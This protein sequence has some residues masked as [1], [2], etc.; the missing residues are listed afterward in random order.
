MFRH[1]LCWL[2]LATVPSLAA[3]DAALIGQPA[4]LTVV[5]TAVT[6]VGPLDRAQV[7][8]TGD[9]NRD[10]TPVADY[11]VEPAHVASVQAGYLRPLQAG[12]ATLVIR[13]GT[14]TLRVPVTVQANPTAPSFRQQVIAALNV[15]GCNAGACHGTPSGKNGFKLSLRG[16][17]PAADFLQLTR[18]LQGRRTDRL[19]PDH[20]LLVQKGLGQTAHEGSQRW[21]T[22]GLAVETVQAWIAAGVPDDAPQLP[23]LVGVTVTP[24]PRVLGQRWQQLAVVARWADGR[25]RDVTRLSNFSS[26]DAG[27]AD[28]TAEGVLEFR[29]P[30]EVSVLVRYLETLVAVRFLYLEPKPGLVWSAPPAVNFV[31]THVHNKLKLLSLPAAPVCDDSTFLRRS[32]LDILGRLPTALEARNF[33]NNPAADKRN[34][35]LDYLLQQ[36]EYADFWALKW[37]DVLRANRKTVQL[38]GVFKYQRWLRQQLLTDVPFDAV[39]RD[40]LT[41]TGDTFAQPAANF[42]RANRDPLTLAET[43]AQLFLGV[44]LQCAKCHNHPFEQWTQDDYYRFA[45][46]F[47]R[48][49]AR[50]NKAK[51]SA[52]TIVVTRAGEVIHPRTGAVALPHFPGAG[53]APGD[54]DRRQALV[55]WLTQRDN[56]FFAKAVVNRVWYHL[57]GR[58]IVEPVDDFRA[59]N[60]ACNDELLTALANDWVQ[61]GYNFRHLLRTIARSHTYQASATPV[62]EEDGRYFS[63]ATPRLLTAEQ[64]LDAVADVTGVAEKFGGLPMGTRAIQVA[65]AGEHAF[66][67]SF[68]QPARELACECERESASN[69]GQALQLLNGTTVHDKIRAANNRLRDYAKVPASE[70]LDELYLTALARWPKPTERAAALAHLAGRAHSRAAWEDVLWALLNTKEFVFRP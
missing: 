51:E 24:G 34:H 20:S 5:P 63:H 46:F 19:R 45:A 65:D 57:H 1:S 7:V 26:S 32:S 35:W 33:A 38:A 13:A 2:F 53:P 6:L 43:T 41:A 39:V 3:P 47:A 52:E 70:L 42:Y 14:H 56:P 48:V 15:G 27:T 10:L 28:V 8:V 12:S 25:T 69:L 18:D 37:A 49:K 4:T 55:D 58:G 59:S 36:P 29:R 60:P 11:R 16:F 54:G 61:S 21:P 40:L 9:P 62:A 67:K 23:A 17:D 22:G 50:P 64:L 30:G 31:D 44:R 68:G 66:M